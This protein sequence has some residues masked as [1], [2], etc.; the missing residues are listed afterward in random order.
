MVGKHKCFVCMYDTDNINSLRDHINNFHKDWFDTDICKE[1][2]KKLGF[3]LSDGRLVSSKPTEEKQIASTEKTVDEEKVMQPV[4]ELT[5]NIESDEKSE[6]V[7]EPVTENVAVVRNT[8]RRSK[9]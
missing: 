5:E 2:C 1:F 6:P 9:K 3:E 4:E 7:S 8:Q